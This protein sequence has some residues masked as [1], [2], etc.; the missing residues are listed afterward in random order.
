MA[1]NTRFPVALH[2]VLHLAEPGGPPIRSEWLAAC[3][4]TN[5]VVVRR[6]LARL[7]TAGLVTST[8]GLGGGWS[9]VRHP[10]TLT[11]QE[12]HAALDAKPLA[13]MRATK[14][15]PGCLQQHAIADVLGEVADSLEARLAEQLRHLTVADVAGRARQLGIERSRK[16][17][18]AQ[19]STP[20]TSR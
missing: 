10:R 19:R 12:I 9:L 8:P 7:R 14:C 20:S 13:A 15:R 4:H 5:P 6:T 17:A 18:E 1:Y 2:L 3:A 11:L 16:R